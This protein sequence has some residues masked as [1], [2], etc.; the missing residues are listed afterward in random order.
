VLTEVFGSV[1]VATQDVEGVP[2]DLD[3]AANGHVAWSDWLVVVVNVL[4]LVSVQELALD[5]SGVL[6]GWLVDGDAV[7]SQVEGDNEAAINVFR[8]FRVEAGC[9]SEDLLVIVDRLEEVAL[10]LVWDELVDVA[11]SVFL[12]SDTVVGWDQGGDWLGWGW[13]CDLSKWEVVAVFLSVELLGGLVD[14]FDLKNA[15]ESIDVALWGDLVAGQVVVANEGLSWLVDIEAVWELLSTEEQGKCVAAV[16]RVVHL[17][18]LDSV[19]GQVVVDD[20]W[21]VVGAGE[22]PENTSIVIEEL[23]LGGNFAATEGLLEELLHLWVSLGWNLDQGLGEVIDW[24]LLSCGKLDALAREELSSIVVTV[25][26][27]HDSAEDRDVSADAEVLGEEW[28]LGA[29]LLDDHLALEEGTLW[30][31]SVR[32]LRLG[33]HDRLVFEEV[34]D[35]HFANPVVLEATFDNALLEV[36]VES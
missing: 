34:I 13:E 10:G 18:D 35:G 31:S 25:V 15:S 3:V 14:A 33:D 22:E 32:D 16:V 6:L 7:V 4:V 29:V 26:N 2:I 36:G 21:E 17:T 27:A 8:H 19:I 9:E 20:V 1:I 5:N 28:F 24:A 30:L 11:E 23:L 12:V